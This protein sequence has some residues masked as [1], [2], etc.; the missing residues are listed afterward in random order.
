MIIGCCEGGHRAHG[1]SPL[2]KTLGIQ[3][4]HAGDNIS[5][6]GITSVL[7]G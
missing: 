1:G 3:S 7:G 5:T 2:G 4:I 6:G